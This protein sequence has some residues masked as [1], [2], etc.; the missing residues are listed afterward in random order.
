MEISPRPSAQPPAS[1]GQRSAAQS[2]H[3]GHPGGGPAV[4]AW[5]CRIR[6]SCVP[7]STGRYTT[8][9]DAPAEP[10]SQRTAERSSRD[11]NPKSRITLVPSRSASRASQMS[12]PSSSGKGR[13]S[14]T[15]P[16]P[17]TWPAG[18]D[19]H[20]RLHAAG[21]R[22]EGVRRG[23]S[24]FAGRRGRAVSPRYRRQV[25]AGTAPGLV[26]GDAA[27]A[28]GPY[29][30]DPGLQQDRGVPQPAQAGQ[31]ARRRRPPTRRGAARKSSWPGTCRCMAEAE[32]G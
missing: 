8:W 3:P 15:G 7:R 28:A 30:R 17:P 21:Q 24:P 23:G 19:P 26:E 31:C 12:R 27:G 29:E 14:C 11:Q 25:A 18:P 16:G 13:P 4:R 32:R 5:R 1:D 20:A 6:A 10:A 2:P 22:G 9:H